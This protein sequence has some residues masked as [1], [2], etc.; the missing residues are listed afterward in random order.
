LNLA[1]SD[2]ITPYSI[3]TPTD[4]RL[5]A[6]GQAINL[7]SL[8]PAKVG[9]ASD[10]VV[11]YSSINKTTYN[12]VEFTANA[13]RNKFI[14]FG[15]VT[16]DKRLSTTCDDRDSLNDLRFCDAPQPFRTTFKASAAYTLPWDI[17]VSGSFAAIPGPAVAANYTVTSAIAG[18]PIIGSTAGAASL[19][20]NLVQPGTL[21]LDY[22][23]RL[24]LRFGRTFRFNQNK[25]QVFADVFNV[26]NAGTVLTVNQ[27]Y[28][29][30]GANAWM[31]PAT[32][33][34]GRYVRFGLQINF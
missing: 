22:Q 24:D 11:T 29:A 3:P 14:V 6:S 12:G 25:F 16:V 17:N 4:S 31:T 20:I 2:W 32:I 15:G 9:I 34:D 5:P 8:N 30:S 28:A 21:F 1:P 18:R 26:L 13:R 7:Y 19:V 27:T 23:N 10:T 33:M